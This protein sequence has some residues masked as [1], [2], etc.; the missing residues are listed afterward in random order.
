L[1][2]LAMEQAAA[3]HAP[4]AGLGLAPDEPVR[5]TFFSPDTARLPVPLDLPSDLEALL[6]DYTARKDALKQELRDRLV[7]LD[8]DRNA[9]RRARS[10]QDLAGEQTVRLADLDVLADRIREQLAPLMQ[11]PA[12]PPVLPGALEG[13]V[14]AYLRNKSDLQRIAQE[15]LAV[16]LAA[17]DEKEK[18][19]RTAH[20]PG[21][22][23]AVVRAAVDAFHA[24]QAA[25]I[26]ALNAEAEA[27]RGELARHAARSGSAAHANKSM[28]ALLR[29]FADAFKRQQ[30]AALY[31]E[32]R[33]ALLE[34]GLSPAQRRLLF[35]GA[36][37]D[38]RLPGAIRDQQVPADETLS[39]P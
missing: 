32:Y 16:A 2:E 36:I 39:R 27:I 20:R 18:D 23:A 4:G 30:L 33:T 9:T 5:V 19:E 24:E 15:R 13:R 17:F 10:L 6:A 34:P 31:A 29:E 28:D 8:A 1:R 21:R 11:P 25:T 35:D 22:R 7:R 37:A 12:V 3:L 14:A 38:L 26:T